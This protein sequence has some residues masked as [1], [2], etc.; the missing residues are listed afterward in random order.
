MLLYTICSEHNFRTCCNLIYARHAGDLMR[1]APCWEGPHKMGDYFGIMRAF[2]LCLMCIFL[3][4]P[5]PTDLGPP[6]KLKSLC[7]GVSPKTYMFNLSADNYN[8]RG[9]HPSNFTPIF[10]PFSSLRV[11]VKKVI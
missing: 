4:D 9:L 5:D 6:K 8:M 2:I 1:P 10:I 3:R 11:G 7:V